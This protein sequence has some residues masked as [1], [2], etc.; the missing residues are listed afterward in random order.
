MGSEHK[1]Y[2][3]VGE[4]VKYNGITAA[5]VK[6]AA[7]KVYLE[8]GEDVFVADWGEGWV[9]LENLLKEN[10]NKIILP[11]IPYSAPNWKPVND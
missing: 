1:S 5:I 3:K 2:F 8:W 10:P 6:L 4:F 9:L 7:D 11:P